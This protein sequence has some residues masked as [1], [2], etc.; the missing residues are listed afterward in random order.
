MR[1]EDL[2]APFAGLGDGVWIVGGCLRD[3]LLGRPVADVDLA[4]AGDASALARGFAKA[5]GAGRFPLS[6]EFGAWRVLGGDLPYT[7][8]ITPVQGTGLGDDLSRRDLSVN[9]MALPVTGP[10]QLV[11]PHGGRADTAARVLRAVGPGSFAA[12]PVRV[13]RAARI[14]DQTGFAVDPGTARLAREAAPS[15]WTSS[16]ERLR[17]ELFRMARSPTAWLALERLDGLGGLGVL[18]PQ[19]EAARGVEQNAYHHRDVLG[20]TLEVVEHA[21]RLAADPEPVFRGDAARLE[22]IL[23]EPLADGLTR[24]QGLVVAALLHDMAKPATRAV[25]PDGRV[26]FFHHD[27][28]G[29][30]Q[31]DDLLTRLRA[32]NRLR[33][34]VTALVRDHLLLGFM[35]HR[36][37]LSVVQADRYLRATEPAATEQIVLSVADRLATDGPRTTP[38]QITRHLDLAR[39]VLRIH[40]ALLDR[41][42][43]RPPLPGDRLAAAV[44]AAPGPWLSEVI[45]RLRERQLTRE[46]T[47]EAAVRFA[48]DWLSIHGTAVKDPHEQ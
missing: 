37:P 20:H 34:Q 18:V 13:L 35:V 24:G 4:V 6:T 33:A 19:L 21:G 9:A 3:A 29:A 22:A 43:I 42:P 17:D 46:V 14:A 1:L 27:R 26:T 10:P 38:I 41:G 23:A 2:R 16:P 15:L 47:P 40:L 44:G 25:Q 11:D 39:Q 7:V 31:A 28:A 32:A 8:D 45:D 30:A 36:Q 12:D 48:A 5:R